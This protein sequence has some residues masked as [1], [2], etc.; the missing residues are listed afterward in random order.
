MASQAVIHGSQERTSRLAFVFL[1]CGATC[2]GMA[3][4]LVRI[5][6]LYAL[7]TAFYRLFLALPWLWLWT[8]TY[9]K[10]AKHGSKALEPSPGK[11]W[12][13]I[14]LGG[15][16]FALDMAFWHESLHHTSIANAT[17]LTN[18]APIFVALAARFL[19]HERLTR[20]F[21]IG[22]CLALVGGVLL[23]GFHLDS[24]GEHLYGDG[25][26]MLAALFY[27]AYMLSIK[28]LRSSM[29][30]LPMLARMGLFST[31]TLGLISLVSEQTMIPA[32]WTG[33]VT[34]CSLA[35]IGQVLGQGLIAYGF[36]HLPASLSALSLLLQPLVASLA[37]W[38]ILKETMSP[39]QIVGGIIV[40]YGISLARKTENR[41]VHPKT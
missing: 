30:T 36:K 3:P 16:F 8:V 37:A 23:S 38:M 31:A 32:S 6:E 39:I 24:Q 11:Q 41:I 5:S 14:A 15:V 19:F 10:G 18:T 26:A 28:W 1:L 17:L 21:L 22:M 4:I 25:M 27:A 40:L 12:L 13:G 9:D 7:P 34:L 33:W 29:D 2:I 20:F 35:F